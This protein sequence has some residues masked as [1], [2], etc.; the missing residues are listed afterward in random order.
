LA[1]DGHV[2]IR[3]EPISGKVHHSIRFYPD[4]ASLIGPFQ[5]AFIQVYNKPLRLI[6]HKNFYELR[7]DSKVI[8]NDLMSF[9]E[10]GISTW[11][12]P[13]I[14]DNKSK[15][16]W[17]R[18]FFDAE[19]YVCK[20][21]IRLKTINKS[22]ILAI[23]KLLNEFGMNTKFYIYKPKN[24]NWSTNY[25]LDIKP[26]DFIKFSKII[27]FNHSIKREKLEALLKDRNIIKHAEVA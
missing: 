5:S 2:A 23:K 27:G 25:I 18:A 22:G 1:G 20:S 21:R 11:K 19:G 17:V 16:E 12:V 13:G 4:H 3:R 8:V 6:R 26:V 14:K 10:F 24:K 15:K 9:S 7:T